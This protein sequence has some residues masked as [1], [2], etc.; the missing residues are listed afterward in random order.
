MGIEVC[1]Y[2]KSS[3]EW[4]SLCFT[5]HNLKMK[6]KALKFRKKF[7]LLSPLSSLLFFIEAPKYTL[8]S[9]YNLYKHLRIHP[10]QNRKCRF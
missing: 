8:S 7:K 1:N 2:S 4:T 9:T 6:N 5:N 3:H 10:L